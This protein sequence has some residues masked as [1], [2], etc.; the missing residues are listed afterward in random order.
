MRALAK[1]DMRANDLIG[2]LEKDPVRV[3]KLEHVQSDFELDGR[4]CTKYSFAMQFKDG[5]WHPHVFELLVQEDSDQPEI[6]DF[7]EMGW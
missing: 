4:H 2:R 7:W 6:L 1:P 3:G 5:R